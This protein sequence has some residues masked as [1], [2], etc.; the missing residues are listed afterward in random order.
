[1]RR[2]G[3]SVAL[4][5][6]HIRM[7]EHVEREGT[8]SA[9]ALALNFSCS[10]LSERLR[11]LEADLGVPLVAR[12]PRAATLTPAGRV[13]LEHGR[14]VA[15]R[16]RAAEAEVRDIAELRGGRLRLAT[17]RT[18]AP[19]VADAAAYFRRHW[20]GVALTL[21]E[22]EPED[23][24]PAV[25][26]GALDLALAHDYDGLVSLASEG[27][28]RSPLLEDDM[29]VVLPVAHP[30]AATERID[31]T[32]LAGERWVT[33]TPQ[34]AVH[35]FTAAACCRAGFEPDVALASDDYRVVQALVAH[36]AG[37][38]FLP[39]LATRILRS[40]LVALPVAGP[41]LRRRVYAVHRAGGERT[42]AVA[43]ML[44]VLREAAGDDR[45]GASEGA[46][47][48]TRLVVREAAA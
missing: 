33:S 32:R 5:L 15:A 18:A 46:G 1:M 3:S 2:R 11:R 34:S 20:P 47:S 25:R 35:L 39:R 31:L 29:L 30:A 41:P 7:L 21:R 43:A 28:G 9:A 14:V 4:D 37:V 26:A 19:L 23:Y 38:A 17:F 10:S 48:S 40:G 22:G 42:P 27:L 8:I 12:A 45:T 36:G 6:P 24:L 16:L 13:L 44:R